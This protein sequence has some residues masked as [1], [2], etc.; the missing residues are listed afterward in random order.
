M[1][2]FRKTRGKPAKEKSDPRSQLKYPD[3]KTLDARGCLTML[4]QWIRKTA[5]LGTNSGQ[6]AP[7]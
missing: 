3:T 1:S 5:N 7:L 6:T 2:S 4:P